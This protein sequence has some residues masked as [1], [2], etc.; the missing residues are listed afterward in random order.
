MIFFLSCAIPFFRC[1]LILYTS[2]YTSYIF[3]FSHPILHMFCSLCPFLLQ[4]FVAL[5]NCNN[6][7]CLSR[8]CNLHTRTKTK[9]CALIQTKKELYPTAFAR[10]AHFYPPQDTHRWRVMWTVHKLL[11]P[12]SG[13]GTPHCAETC[14][15][16]HNFPE[17]VEVAEG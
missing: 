8:F 17:L 6:A 4:F 14:Y 5:S 9:Q 3:M 13:K 15:A 11:V 10:A 2:K 1:F 7:Y 16:C 12:N